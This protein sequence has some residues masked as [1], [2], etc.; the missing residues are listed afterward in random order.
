[1]PRRFSEASHAS[2]KSNRENDK[3]KNERGIFSM[4][5]HKLGASMAAPFAFVHKEQDQYR[6]TGEGHHWNQ[7]PTYGFQIGTTCPI[8]HVGH[9]VPDWIQ[10]WVSN[11]NMKDATN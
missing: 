11:P 3:G 5:A 6:Q 9:I 4:L 7:D 10:R 2:L 1:M 8:M